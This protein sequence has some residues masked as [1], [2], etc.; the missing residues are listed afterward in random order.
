MDEDLF[1]VFR[2]EAEIVGPADGL[3]G[4]DAGAGEPHGVGVNV[5]VA[6]DCLAGLAHGGAAEF[7]AEDDQRIFQQSS[8]LEVLEQRGA[9]L[10]DLLAA[11]V[12]RLA[13]VLI[14]AAMVVP[15]G[16]IELDE[17]DVA[18]DEASREQAVVGE[19]AA[20]GFG[21]VHRASWDLR[22]RN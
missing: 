18:L 1:V 16:V 20:A 17:S 8:L 9:G 6:A 19:G 10:V 21:A 22:R 13:E 7:A 12:K 3:A 4:L 11:I 5:V 15:I 2:R 14:G